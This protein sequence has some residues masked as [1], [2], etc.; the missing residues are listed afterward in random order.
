[1]IAAQ[2]CFVMP[3][4]RRGLHGCVPCRPAWDG[5]RD[6]DGAVSGLPGVPAAAGRETVLSEHPRASRAGPAAL[7]ANTF[8]A[9][10]SRGLAFSHPSGCAI[11]FIFEGIAVAPGFPMDCADPPL[12]RAARVRG[13][14]RRRRAH[15]SRSGRRRAGRPAGEE[16]RIDAQVFSGPIRGSHRSE[17]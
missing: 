15:G 17:R 4:R 14:W 6:G 7:P 8:Q 1:M 3:R 2:G 11:P 10:M 5:R 16:S 12:S 9:W 13:R